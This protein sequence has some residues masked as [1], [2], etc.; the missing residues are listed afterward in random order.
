MRFINFLLKLAACV[1]CENSTV[2][3]RLL[4]IQPPSNLSLRLGFS[5]RLYVQLSLDLDPKSLW[6]HCDH[7]SEV[8]QG[9]PLPVITSFGSAS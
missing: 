1:H 8:W 6:Y 4:Q 9:P 5:R 2:D 3:F 7:S